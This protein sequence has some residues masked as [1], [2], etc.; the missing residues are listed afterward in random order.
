MSHSWKDD[1]IIRRAM[2]ESK[3]KD[4]FENAELVNKSESENDSYQSLK[5]N[6]IALADA[7][8]YENFVLLIKRG[9]KT[10]ICKFKKKI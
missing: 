4:M 7:D 6:M 5:Y 8:G 9:F 1:M 10:E 2:H 3:Y